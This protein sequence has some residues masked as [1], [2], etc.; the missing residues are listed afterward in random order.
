M[1]KCVSPIFLVNFPYIY[2]HDFVHHIHVQETYSDE[3]PT[4]LYQLQYSP[5]LALKFSV[6]FGKP[7]NFI[8]KK[9]IQL[10]SFSLTSSKDFQID[11]YDIF[12]IHSRCSNSLLIKSNEYQIYSLW[13]LLHSESVKSVLIPDW[14]LSLTVKKGDLIEKGR[15][16]ERQLSV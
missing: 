6:F 16:K 9:L 10:C 5:S 15:W 2:D 13:K 14:S 12:L 8:I 11:F 3:K 1:L 7:A 4:Q